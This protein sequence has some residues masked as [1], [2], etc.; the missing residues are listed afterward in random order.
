MLESV[1]ILYKPNMLGEVVSENGTNNGKENKV[2]FYHPDHL[3][4]ASWITDAQACIV[5]EYHYAPYGELIVDNDEFDY[6]DYDERY[7]FTGKERDSETGYDYFGARFFWSAF[8][9]WLSVDPLAEK[10]PGI[11]PYA[12]C[13]WNPIKYKD[14]D[15]NIAQV[16]AG[17]AIGAASD[18]ALQVGMNML[19]GDDFT[20]ALTHDISIGSIVASAALGA[21]GVGI[22]KSAKN[23][24]QA[25]K[26]INNAQK[27]AKQGKKAQSIGRYIAPNGG[28]AK[29]HGGV[30]HNSAIDKGISQSKQQGKQNIRKN[31]TQVD[32][33]GKK[34]GNNRPDI[35]YDENGQH[36]CVEYDT[37][38]N[39]GLKHQQTIQTNDPNAKVILKTVE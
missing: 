18:Y 37:N 10:T 5:H 8:G 12:Y 19:N 35:Q 16:V 31:Q 27:V 15:G 33:S 25:V 3:G 17:A 23:A 20:T 34:V 9:H 22:A 7:K 2:Y 39:N 36:V 30:K 32:A 21:A 1:D 14:P 38:P 6:T 13:N 11:S 4:S 29:P 24:Q 28:K 26:Q